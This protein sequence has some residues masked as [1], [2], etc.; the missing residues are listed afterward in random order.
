MVFDENDDDDRRP[1]E[2]GEKKKKS[3]THKKG[4]ALYKALKENG[5]EMLK[6]LDQSTKES[7]D[8]KGALNDP[9]AGARLF[10]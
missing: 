7:I 3:Q 5:E 9:R 1:E 6:L 4:P 10:P 2:R 8:F